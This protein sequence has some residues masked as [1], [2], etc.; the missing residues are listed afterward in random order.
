MSIRAKIKEIKHLRSKYFICVLEN[1]KL[2]VN[3]ASVIRN[4]SALGIQKIYLIGGYPGIPKSFEESRE[5]KHLLKSSV[6][7]SKWTFIKHFETT[8]E[9]INYLRKN[10]YTIVITSP[11]LKG[12]NNVNL[13]D[14]QFTN[15]RLSI[16]FGNETEGISEE[17]INNSDFCVQVPMGGVVESFNLGTSTGIVLSYIR[18][19]RLKFLKNK[20]ERKKNI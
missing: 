2:S 13:Y 8:K 7:A 12:K 10:F 4:V 19:Q 6:G 9:C 11:H 1:I 17:A 16:W 14:G 3:L 5:N 18:E 20:D 15:K